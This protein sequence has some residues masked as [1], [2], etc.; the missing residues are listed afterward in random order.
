MEETEALGER[1]RY[2]PFIE[3]PNANQCLECDDRGHDDDRARE[4]V[5]ECLVAQSGTMLQTLDRQA[6]NAALQELK[7]RGLSIRQIERL[8]GIS[9]NI[10]QR[11]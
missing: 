4:I 5:L 2:A 11:A 8:T 6:R 1:E 9:R 7:R 3:A 10:V